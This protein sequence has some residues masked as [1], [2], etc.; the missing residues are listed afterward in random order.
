M[1]FES[2]IEKLGT[3]ISENWSWIW[4]FCCLIL[5]TLS[6]FCE[7]C[8]DGFCFIS[9]RGLFFLLNFVNFCACGC[10][11]SSKCCIWIKLFLFHLTLLFGIP[12]SLLPSWTRTVVY[13]FFKFG[14]HGQK[15]LNFKIS[16]KN[17]NLLCCCLIFR[18]FS[19]FYESCLLDFVVYQVEGFFLF[20]LSSWRCELCVCGFVRLDKIIF[21]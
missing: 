13:Y 5:R 10:G 6:G 21:Q 7:P 3:Y 16:F 15:A 2:C 20:Q 17:W 9:S 1:N 18:T 14:I 11:R 19:G 8:G 4:P 12:V